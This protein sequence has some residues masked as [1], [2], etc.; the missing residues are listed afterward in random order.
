MTSKISSRMLMLQQKHCIIDA[1]VG[2]DLVMRC[3]LTAH[4]NRDHVQ[5]A[6]IEVV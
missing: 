2:A 4:F 3:D 6:G 5:S 1:A